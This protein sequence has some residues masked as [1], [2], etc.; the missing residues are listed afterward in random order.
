MSND[1]IYNRQQAFLVREEIYLIQ[2]RAM[3]SLGLARIIKKKICC[4][5]TVYHIASIQSRKVGGRDIFSSGLEKKKK[6]KK[7]RRKERKKSK[8]GG[9]EL[10]RQFRS[11]GL[12]AGKSRKAKS[13][14][15][16]ELCHC[17]PP[18]AQ[19]ASQSPV[20]NRRNF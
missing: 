12:A 7:E 5:S 10:S 14:E 9:N 15:R 17:C 11:I 4:P 18:P 2:D 3:Y 13:R 16:T 8:S 1:Q 20:H 19:P 6:R